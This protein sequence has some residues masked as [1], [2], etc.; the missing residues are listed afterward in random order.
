MF[1]YKGLL[2][3]FAAFPN[4][5]S[6]FPGSGSVVEAFK[7]DLKDYQTSKGAIRFPVDKPL[8]V[9]LL[10]KLVKARIAENEHKK[11]R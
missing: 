6:F 11:Q 10:K 8:P 9:A 4:H 3:G 2:V 1:K 7:H 5:C